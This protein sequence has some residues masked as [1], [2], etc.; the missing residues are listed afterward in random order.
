MR[1]LSPQG[2]AGE[3]R[4]LLIALIL[5]TVKAACERNPSR[6]DHSVKG[7]EAT[8]APG[9]SGKPAGSRTGRPAQPGRMPKPRSSRAV[10]NSGNP[11]TPE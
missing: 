9:N 8:A 3:G 4:G 7:T 6:P 10:S 5:S 11:I 2:E 1:S